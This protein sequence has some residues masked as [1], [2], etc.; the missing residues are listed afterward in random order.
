MATFTSATFIPQLQPYQ[1]D[2][3]LYANLMQTKQT[4]YDSNWKSLNKMYGQYFYADLTRDDNVKKKEYLVDQINFNVNRLTG[5]DLSLEQNVT[6]AAQVFKPFYEDKGLMK[7]MAWTKNFNQQVGRAEALQGSADEKDRAQFWDAG[8]RELQYKRG[9]F[10]DV[11]ADKAMSFENAQYTPYINVQDKALKLA[12][13]FGNIESV[14]FSSD[15]RWVIKQTNGRI[16]EEPLSK[17]F[18]AN[19]GND[20]Q[21]QAIYKTQ[22]YVN[23]KDYSYSNAAQFGGDKNKAEQK[24]L[25]DNFNIL[26]EQSKKRY[27][28]Y[29]E[30]STVY[31]NKIKD[32]QKQVDNGTASP[33]AKEQLAAYIENKRINGAVLER[34]K[35]DY[36]MMNSGESKTATTSTGFK[37]PYGDIES[38]R[39]K[40]D[41]GVS[42]M[43]MQKDLGEAAHVYAYRNAKTSMDANPYAILADKHK[44]E[45]SEIASRIQG[46]KD[47]AILKANM[48][49]QL[50]SDKDK[51]A[52]GTHYR[53]EKGETVEFEN[54]NN[55]YIMPNAKGATT[56]VNSAI[57]LSRK[58][59]KN[60]T[61]NHAL[62][63]VQ[64]M[65][66]VLDE[67]SNNNE[68][69][70]AQIKQILG[71]SRAP[72]ITLQ[73]FKQRL[74]A[75]PVAFVSTLL[76]A[77]GLQR[78]KENYNN[79]ISN[80]SQL[81]TI[82]S[83]SSQIIR[84]NVKFQ[85]Y[86]NYLSEDQKWR[87]TTSK[88]VENEINRVGGYQ[89]AEYLYD[90]KGNLRTEKQFYDAIEKAGGSKYVKDNY[91]N[92]KS[93]AEIK[94]VFGENK[95]WNVI[96]TLLAP[97]PKALGALGTALGSESEKTNYQ[98]LLKAANE[99]WK[100]ADI[101]KAPVVGL[102]KFYDPGT[103]VFT[104]GAT[105]I[106]VSPRSSKGRYYYDGVMKDLM[107]LDFSSNA[108][109]TRISFKGYS[110]DN[111]NTVGAAK[112]DKGQ[113]LIDAIRR[114]MNNPKSKIGTFEL[115]V[116]PIATGSTNRG[117]VIIK[118]S[119]E[120]LSGFKSTDKDGKN[121]VLTT[122]EYNNI[123]TNGINIMTNNSNFKNALYQES[124]KDPL[125]SYV[126]AAGS[127]T[128]TDPTNNKYKYTINKDDY[129]MGDYT[130]ISEFP[131]WNVEKGDYDIYH[132]TSNSLISGNNLSKQRDDQIY[133]AYDQMK[134]QNQ[135]LSNGEY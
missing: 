62:P 33:E 47:I 30:R 15:G 95:T 32:L 131:V 63:W 92:Q 58:I 3:N 67:L 90:T 26:K 106:T 82:K 46:Q 24:Y 1:P 59:V 75:N 20:P 9:E 122:E 89:Y 8:L 37:N 132:S 100:K 57:G 79:F 56:D 28:A 69:D 76:G 14:D 97:I 36:D 21:V 77:D 114:D 40:V 73:E 29:E 51:V 45:M 39:Y 48:Q 7:D 22:S 13:E 55:T 120:W 50:D 68:I 31:D 83:R 17:M 6:Q 125:A 134:A 41:N 109:N 128:Y 54:L 102:G 16:L 117:A 4:Q 115:G 66:G 107:G 91:G 18:E 101:V 38:L 98:E 108:A 135:R 124:F 129:G 104:E 43:L 12:K 86:V 60:Q 35:T 113:A 10:K 111:W 118:P 105:A 42:S 84:E 126:D 65:A 19:L 94:K 49:Q 119:A 88:A 99:V 116:A 71:T 112:L 34:A 61:E 44:Y 52:A 78:I 81:S 11:T 85:D 127:Y 53:N 123:L 74:K 27:N 25:E 23:R 2:L 121:N 133:T 64:S 130:L 93:E 80:N 70:N 72:N 103:G 96:S 5:L 87:A 110:L